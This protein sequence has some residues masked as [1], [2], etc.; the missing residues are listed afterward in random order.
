VH[1][2]AGKG[3][4]QTQP[5]S[6]CCCDRRGV[7]HPPPIIAPLHCPRHLPSE[8]DSAWPPAVPGPGGRAPC[9]GC[10]PPACWLHPACQQQSTCRGGRRWQWAAIAGHAL[11]AVRQRAMQCLSSRPT[12]AHSTA[13]TCVTLQSRCPSSGLPSASHEPAGHSTPPHVDGIE[14]HAIRHG[15]G[16]RWPHGGL[17]RAARSQLNVIHRTF[18]LVSAVMTSASSTPAL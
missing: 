5:D 16:L 7:C 11:L 9:T 14:V 1:G 17:P 13:S 2:A 6:A 8:P 10:R 12:R 15:L 4:H 18:R 3:L